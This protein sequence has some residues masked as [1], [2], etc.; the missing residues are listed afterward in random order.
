MAHLELYL[1]NKEL[2]QL[3]LHHNLQASEHELNMFILKI[4]NINI[5]YYRK[6]IILLKNSSENVHLILISGI[7]N[8]SFLILK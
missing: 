5:I 6:H 7:E 2:K 1:V 4:K 3:E 8:L